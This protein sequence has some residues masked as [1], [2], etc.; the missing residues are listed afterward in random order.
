MTAFR[1]VFL[2]MGLAALAGAPAAHAQSARTV[3]DVYDEGPVWHM[4]YVRTGPGQREAYLDSL[5]G[6]WTAQVELAEEM[7]FVLDHHVLTKWPTSPDDWDVLIIEIF[8]DMAAYDTFWEDWARV[9]AAILESRE[10]E[11]EVSARVTAERTLLGIH[12]AREVFLNPPE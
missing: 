10:D 5:S 6:T 7:G 1:I 8:P 12:V 11:A 3:L 9:D 4:I 2:V